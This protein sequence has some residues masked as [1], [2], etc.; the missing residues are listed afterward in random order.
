MSLASKPGLSVEPSATG[1]CSPA[2]GFSRELMAAY[3]NW[4]Y[5]SLPTSVVKRIKLFVLDT[6]DAL[7]TICCD[8]LI[9]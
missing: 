8:V 5:S 2:D 7:A 9:T 3:E 4:S 1:Q 6:H